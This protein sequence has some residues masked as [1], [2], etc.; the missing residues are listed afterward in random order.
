MVPLA[1]LAVHRL[2][3]L[4]PWQW[5][6]GLALVLSAGLYLARWYGRSVS[7][8]IRQISLLLVLFLGA[9]GYVAW[10]AELA[11]ADRLPAA[12]EGQNLLVSGRVSGLVRRFEFGQ[13]FDFL[14]ERCA[15][16]LRWCE[17]PRKVRLSWYG[18]AG[19]A[20]QLRSGEIWQ[21][22]VRLK[23]PHAPV[24]PGGFDAELRS[25]QSGI[26]AR[27]YVRGATKRQPLE[28][29]NHRISD[30]RLSPLEMIDRARARVVSAMNTSLADW[31]EPVRGTLVALVTGEQ[32]AI[33]PAA[34]REYNRTGTSHLMSISGLHVTLFAALLMALLRRLL[35]LPGLL[36]ASWLNVVPAPAIV[37]TLGACAALGY[38]LFSG[39]GIP[40]QRT[41]LMLAVAGFALHSGR[42]VSIAWVMA[43][44]AALVVLLDPWAPLA[45]G[46]WLSFAAVGAIVLASQGTRAYQE[47][48]WLQAARTQ[49]A[50]TVSLVPLGAVW[51]GTFSVV[52]PLA[53]L[54]A[55][56]VISAVVTP[57]ALLAAFVQW[58][59]PVAG[60]FLLFLIAWP[61]DWLLRGLGALARLPQ[62]VLVVGQPSWVV[63]LPAVF[64][65]WLLLTPSGAAPRW[66]GVLLLLPLLLLPVDPIRAGQWRLLALDIGQGNSVLI[67][68]E[69]HSL[70]FDTGPTYRRSSGAGDRIVAPTLQSRQISRLN[71]LIVSHQ[72]LDHAGGAP[73]VMAMFDVGRLLTSMPASHPISQQA[74]RYQSCERGMKWQW[75]GVSFEI[76]HPGAQRLSVAKTNAR[77]CVLMVRGPGGSA[78]LTGDIEAAQE[79][80]ILR[81]YQPDRLQADVLMAPH[82]G[83]NTSSTQA[84][85]AAVDP[86]WA[87]FQ[88]GY[89]NRFRHPTPKVLRR[90]SLAGIQA[91]RSDQHGALEWRFSAGQ[92]PVLI[93]HRQH[94]S[95]YW[96]VQVP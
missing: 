3:V 9:S 62:A 76:L 81:L 6:L 72:D 16:K 67:Q 4:A 41:S 94:Q 93:R 33:P 15:R 42:I 55:I 59:L 27:G 69:H 19:M 64:G 34:W 36:P 75:D 39:W 58:L 25:L 29:P 56:P 2:P 45:S 11:L 86:V 85:L 70:L 44:A 10:R 73:A 22:T 91:L 50:A 66:L 52:S 49:W 14:I 30:G 37:V 35:R 47:A 57:V 77:S 68:T 13:G 26:G 63:L 51:F 89:R 48:G 80:E 74:S 5:L 24:N 53:N 90:Y 18:R 7:V 46:F 84:F 82:H 65:V 8:G 88:M 83:S 61:T 78:L 60:D 28:Q 1:A 87:F 31:S 12:L 71:A 96:R 79:R 23:R 40:A 20:M 32:S 43:A 54:V 92:R 38:S 21:L 95:R 17:S